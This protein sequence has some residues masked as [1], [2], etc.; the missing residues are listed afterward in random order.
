MDVRKKKIINKLNKFGEY[1]LD[2]N[3]LIIYDLSKLIDADNIFNFSIEMAKYKDLFD[4]E[5]SMVFDNCLFNFSNNPDNYYIN[6]RHVADKISF[7]NC[8]FTNASYMVF[9]NDACFINCNFYSDIFV[10]GLNIKF[11]GCSFY[12]SS[13]LNAM[14]EHILFNKDKF[15]SGTSIRMTG[16]PK[17]E[18]KNSIFD[19]DSIILEDIRGAEII[20]SRIVSDIL[21]AYSSRIRITDTDILSCNVSMS[22]ADMCVN[23]C[24]INSNSFI[25]EGDYFELDECLFYGDEICIDNSTITSICSSVIT[26]KSICLKSP[27]FSIDKMSKICS[28]NAYLEVNVRPYKKI[29]SN[30]LKVKNVIINDNIITSNDGKYVDISLIEP[31]NNLI[32]VLKQ[33]RD[34]SNEKIE[35]LSREY[36]DS[37]K[38]SFTVSDIENIKVLKKKK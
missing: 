32:A 38:H 36:E 24:S 19:S 37:I 18:F 10:N 6:L 1:D 13:F 27:Y 26:G 11:D 4:K 8:N 28:D 25:F 14:A 16:I 31:R 15:N 3:T 20:S 21:K 29:D 30:N 9:L 5:F 2:N 35:T 23:N 17:I 33:I 7:K 12:N 34:N 22:D